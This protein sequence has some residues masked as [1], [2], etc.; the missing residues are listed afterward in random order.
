MAVLSTQ[1][2]FTMPDDL[3]GLVNIKF[4]SAL[5]G[6]TLVF[7]SRVDPGYGRDIRRAPL[8]GYAGQRLYLVVYNISDHEV[9]VRP[10]DP[11]FMV[12]FHTIDGPPELEERQNNDTYVASHIA[13]IGGFGRPAGMGARVA[14][15]EKDVAK[16][17]GLEPSVKLVVAGVAALLGVTLLGTVAGF[18]MAYKA[19]WGA[20]TVQTPSSLLQRRAAEVLSPSNPTAIAGAEGYVAS[21]GGGIVVVKAKSTLGFNIGD[22]GVVV[23]IGGEAGRGAQERYVANV[24]FV[25]KH[26]DTFVVRPLGAHDPIR[27]GDVVRRARAEGSG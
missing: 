21:V 1:E 11:L 3:V 17:K 7:G 16:L 8:D 6:M 19:N 27:V 23:R 10:G 22:I 5:R 15:L 14:E 20:M 4:K 13:E 12:E 26:G 2:Q 25:E 18:F 24:R 9:Y